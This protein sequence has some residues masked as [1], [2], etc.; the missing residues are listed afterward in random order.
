MVTAGEVKTEACADI[1]DDK[2]NAV[3]CAELANLLPV[4]VCGKLVVEE[5]A[6]EIG[7]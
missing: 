6:V 1:V 2:D 3:L 7:S 5:V 4:T